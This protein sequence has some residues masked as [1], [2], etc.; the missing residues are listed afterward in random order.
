MDICT[1]SDPDL[2]GNYRL[3][4]KNVII[5]IIPNWKWPENYQLLCGGGGIIYD[6]DGNGWKLLLGQ[7]G[8]FNEIVPTSFDNLCLNRISESG[9]EVVE[10]KAAAV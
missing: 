1:E 6:A 2:G 10:E 9:V 4:Q 5:I 8:I 7:F 3:R